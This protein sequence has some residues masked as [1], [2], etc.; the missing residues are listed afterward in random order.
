MSHTAKISVND[1]ERERGAYCAA[2]RLALTVIAVCSLGGCA[3]LDLNNQFPWFA[4]DDQPQTPDR[5]ECVWTNTV[6]HRPG[7][8]GV[9]G[10]GGRVLFYTQDRKD[11]VIVHGQLTV[12][13]FDDEITNPDNAAPEKKY[14]FPA[15]HLP[16]HCSQ[17]ALGHSYSFWLPWDEVDGRQRQISLIARFEDQ[18][19]KN[20]MSEL[21]HLALPGETPRPPD[22]T[23]TSAQ[24]AAAPPASSSVKQVSYETP[25][26]A[27]RSAKTGGLEE[28]PKMTT[29]TIDVT[30]GFAS[31]LIAG[32][33][34]QGVASSPQRVPAPTVPEKAPVAAPPPDSATTAEPPAPSPETD[35]LGP[36]AS[37]GAPSTHFALEQFQVRTEP[38]T[39]PSADPVRR[40]PH[41]ARSLSRLPPTPRSNWT[42]PRTTLN[43]AGQPTP[44]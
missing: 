28:K 24:G 27:D 29:T 14:I 43:S 32:G 16:K 12:Y 23:A 11:P 36:Q 31:K 2:R 44:Y 8:A 35:S 26:G 41:R 40:G 21:A 1:H 7:K 5:M 15:V 38:A 18:S 25:A 37:A 10:F 17:S 9:R 33:A 22:R 30:P 20:V 6:L 39:P 4:S 42:R 13:A 34:D 3:E 19:G